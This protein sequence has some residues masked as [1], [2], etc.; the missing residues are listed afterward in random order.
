VAARGIDALAA[1]AVSDEELMRIESA[2]LE[3][4]RVPRFLHPIQHVARVAQGWNR[5]VIRVE[6][7]LQRYSP[8]SEVVNLVFCA[9]GSVIE[10]T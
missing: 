10:E 6:D 5:R 7:L 4:D 1:H 9:G 2:E 8:A 3:R